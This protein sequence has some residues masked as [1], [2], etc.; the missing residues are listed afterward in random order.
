MHV[1]HYFVP[2][3]NVYNKA[4]YE[5]KNHGT[6]TTHLEFYMNL[7]TILTPVISHREKR[8]RS[9]AEVGRIPS[10]LFQSI[11]QVAPGLSSQQM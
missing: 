1:E 7:L 8:T 2:F 6:N 5:G 3:F 10:S 11:F 4:P 9:F